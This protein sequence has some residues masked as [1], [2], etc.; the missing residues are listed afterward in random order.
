MPVPTGKTVAASSLTLRTEHKYLAQLRC[1]VD[2]LLNDFVELPGMDLFY[3]LVILVLPFQE[4]FRMRKGSMQERC[5]VIFIRCF[6]YS[7]F[8]LV[9]I[10]QCGIGEG[11]KKK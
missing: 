7:F 11:C 3:F 4:W 10:S 2:F 5:M 6:L 1:P 9:G 8:C